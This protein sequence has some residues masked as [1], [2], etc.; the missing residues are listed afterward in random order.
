MQIIAQE[1]AERVVQKIIARKKRALVVFTGANIGIDEAL[2]CI[3]A[4]RKEGF[5]FQ[6]LFSEA[7]EQML[8]MTKIRAAFAPEEMPVGLNQQVPSALAMAY[9][10]IL[11]PTLTIRSVAH[12]AS[13][14][15]DTH[16]QAVIFAG[17]MRGKTVIAAVDG[18][19]PD[20]P[21]RAKRGY[22]PN[23]ALKQKLRDN[24]SQFKSFGATLTTADRLFDKTMRS[25]QLQSSA[26][27]SAPVAQIAKTAPAISSGAQKVFDGGKLL[28]QQYIF[29]CADGT[30]IIVPKGTLIT[31]LAK[32]EA[33][34]R[35]VRI[36]LQS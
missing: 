27:F 5:T 28:S 16:A 13:G 32:D 6:V 15:T 8:D 19:C 34:K 14:A 3:Y 29:G 25:L 4:L 18:C 20:N 35:N 12:L 11:V 23:E 26:A 33:R 36:Q 7:A 22:T 1:I 2:A 17:L 21:L 10:T 24:M 9:E 31:Q 30:T